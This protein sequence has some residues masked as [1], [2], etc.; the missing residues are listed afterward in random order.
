MRVLLPLLLLAT[1]AAA[2]TGRTRNVILVM[3]D[4]LRWQDVFRGADP[5]L[6]NKQAGG[7]SDVDA[8][9]KEFWRESPAERRAALL[10]FL[11]STVA[12]QGQIFGNRDAG[13]EAY[14]TNG[15]NFSYPGYSETLCGFV[16]P[17]VNSNNKIPNPNVTVFEWLHAKPAF[18][19]K[20]AGFGAWDVFPYIFN[21]ARAGFPVNAGSDAFTMKPMPPGLA[22]MNRLKSESAIWSSEAFDTF[23]FHTAMMYLR[24]KK[25]RLLY[26]SLGETDEW[27]HEGKYA[28]YLRAAHRVDGYL[29]E[30]WENVQAMPQ[31]R[32]NTT[33]IFLPDHG[34]GEAPV[35]WKSHGPKIAGSKYIWM[36]VLGP[37]TK[38]QGERKQIGPVT[39][40]QVAATL[41]ALLGEDYRKDVP[42]AGA[43]I[44]DVLR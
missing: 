25:P 11:W 4:G 41:A 40:N 37:D 34:R 29:K 16:D 3:T 28:E 1:S 32:G 9:R 35:E 18:K 39:Q 8:L 10:P 19:G 33:L 7:V 27:S 36:A 31:Y 22:L 38:A 13:S 14:V 30:L 21:A 17:G 12:T 42:K 5:A 15:L 43:P 26:L 44:A 2:Q 20:V 24:E 6:L 23:T